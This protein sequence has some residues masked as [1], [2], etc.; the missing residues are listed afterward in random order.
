MVAQVEHTDAL[1]AQLSTHR[2]HSA[3]LRERTRVLLDKSSR[4]IDEYVESCLSL[5]HDVHH[6]ITKIESWEEERTVESS[7]EIAGKKVGIVA[8]KTS[9]ISFKYAK[10]KLFIAGSGMVKTAVERIPLD[11]MLE[12][13]RGVFKPKDHLN[14]RYHYK[15]AEY[16]RVIFE[17]L[18]NSETAF[19][20]VSWVR[21]PKDPMRPII[22]LRQATEA[23]EP[24][25][26]WVH[27]TVEPGTFSAD[28]LALSRNGVRATKIDDIFDT[29]D[30]DFKKQLAEESGSDDGFA[31]PF[32]NQSIARDL[33]AR[34]H[35]Q[36]IH[37]ANSRIGDP[38]RDGIR[39]LKIWI[40]RYNIEDM[41]HALTYWTAHLV[42]SD[43]V[44]SA[45]SALEI[46][47][48]VLGSIA[49]SKWDTQGF[50]ICTQQ[51]S[52][53]VS[54]GLIVMDHEGS[55]NIMN[56][57]SPET[58]RLLRILSQ[59]AQMCLLDDG[60]GREYIGGPSIFDDLFGA[61]RSIFEPYDAYYTVKI[62][63]KTKD[64]TDISHINLVEFRGDMMAAL[65]YR[66]E[67]V[68]RQGLGQ[69]AKVV[70]VTNMLTGSDKSKTF[71]V[72][73]RVNCV[74]DPEHAFRMVD[75]GPRADDDAAVELFRKFWGERAELRR[76]KDGSIVEAVVWQ[77]NHNRRHAIIG[78]IMRFVLRRQLAECVVNVDGD[79]MT[80]LDPLIS[81]DDENGDA[82]PSISAQT[83]NVFELLT[84]RMRSLSGMP[85]RILDIHP[86]SPH[87]RHTALHASTAIHSGEDGKYFDLIDALIV[88]EGS[89]KW[90]S[91][92][93]QSRA[94]LGA[95]AVQL[96]NAMEE[97]IEDVTGYFRQND[98]EDAF[99]LVVVH[100]Q[101]SF[102]FLLQPIFHKEDEADED[103]APTSDYYCG[104]FSRIARQHACHIKQMA[105]T[106][107][108][109]SRMVRLALRW[110]DSQI[111]LGDAASELLTQEAI[112]MIISYLYLHPG[113]F[114]RPNSVPCG[115]LRLLSF[116]ANTES[117]V[118]PLVVNFDGQLTGGAIKDAKSYW[119]QRTEITLSIIFI[120]PQCPRISPY[121]ANLSKTILQRASFLANAA[122]HGFHQVIK[123]GIVGDNKSLL[124][125]IFAPDLS[126]YDVVFTLA[127]KSLS[128]R[129][130]AKISE[131]SETARG[132]S[133]YKN[134]I[135]GASRKRKRE[136]QNEGLMLFLG[137]F[138]PAQE[139]AK[140]LR[141]RFGHTTFILHSA[142]GG[143]QIAVKFAPSKSALH[144]FRVPHLVPTLPLEDVKAR[145]GVSQFPSKL[146]VD[147]SLIVRDMIAVAGDMI[148]AVYIR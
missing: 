37:E 147:T 119:A 96:M 145:K 57:I 120:T 12:M 127:K 132:P 113:R 139:L 55:C 142:Y 23:T 99:E 122:L 31:T 43:V 116:F 86:L 45:M 95:Y 136:S 27:F 87:L 64:L 35:L 41:S 52:H 19:H 105:L 65:G 75:T 115:F 18:Q 2:L 124:E 137:G 49:C 134:L 22:E 51:G 39:L 130:M 106:Y 8:T 48:I 125:Q 101:R 32:Y 42:H 54:G 97:Q 112:E 148:S 140:E 131:A 90:P 34:S 6:V 143:S 135:P 72:T 104:P 80:V 50:N 29:G 107:P 129:Y 1:D 89:G 91:D 11:I 10:P 17:A 56:Q 4:D 67:E 93:E 88:V 36:Y 69:R 14:F 60:P 123:G 24:V 133:K 109:F 70:R 81:L 76:F 110:F 77:G 30:R 85:L 111:L 68:L 83:A 74:F 98:S 15:R 26:L 126:D 141:R 73:C 63:G 28:R 146:Q 9:S 138:D 71:D 3:V 21:H 58:Y 38:F 47:Q 128:R 94:M 103:D 20:S 5:A 62:S 79:L 61:L 144:A 44:K 13:P 108:S 118:D 16:A 114:Q 92:R 84:S 78:Q 40:Q 66:I 121:T 117:F 100:Q 102:R 82:S 59:R 33:C 7:I 46:F 53:T 25:L